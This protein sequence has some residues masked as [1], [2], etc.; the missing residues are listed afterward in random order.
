MKKRVGIVGAGI[1]GLLACKYTI[2]NGFHPAVFEA[3]D[4]IGGV[5]SQ[6]ME[7]T[8]LQNPRDSFQF[9]DFPWPASVK[10]LH[11]SHTQVMEYLESYAQHFN[12]F[13]YIRFNCRVISLDYVGVP[14]EEM[15]TW[16]LWGGTGRAFS[17]RGK[18]NLKLQNT[19]RGCIE[20]YQFEFVIL[21]IGKHSGF[22]NIPEFLPDHGPEVYKGKVVH[23]M[24]Y[25]ALENARAAELVKGKTVAIIGSQKSAID[26]ATECA[27]VNGLDNPCTLIQRTIYWMLPHSHSST[28]NLDFLFFS[29]FSELMVHK[30]GET[31]LHSILATLL[32]PLRWA[33]SKLVESYFRWELPLKKYGMIPKH[34]FLEQFC[35]C[36]VPLLPESFY[37][38][39]AEG[40]II[41]KKSQSIRFCQEGLIVDYEHEPLKADIVILATG[42]NGD[43]KL[44]NMFMSTTFRNCIRGPAAKQVP[45]YRQIIE[46]RIP[47]LGI[48]GYPESY[49]NL[50]GS[51][52]RC[53]WLAQFLCGNFELPSIREMEK[54]IVEWENYMKRYAG[55][56]F[57]K[58]CI[59]IP[60]WCN[61]Q[62]C[63]DMGREPRRK[64]GLF[65]E[66]FEPYGPLDYSGLAE[67]K[68]LK[69]LSSHFNLS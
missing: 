47:Q 46:P 14:E 33:I 58:T 6:T 4:S 8:K 59:S 36:Q 66:L 25:S 52:I 37:R 61:D 1:S 60:I 28:V 31:T 69:R 62:L 51:E 19:E 45:L 49:S 35:S 55:K 22:P 53:Q 10:E 64:K 27:S 30:P 17:A 43:E 48:I 11:P 21:C 16:Y 56:Y 23:S 42:F 41:L 3:Q 26:V 29:R 54:E 65:A 38:K 32:S 9:S 67:S 34:S 40:S 13:P 15:Q 18:W 50:Q 68:R 12:L 39:V 5:W 7:S 2:E 44:R 20:E 24:E 57:W 63:R